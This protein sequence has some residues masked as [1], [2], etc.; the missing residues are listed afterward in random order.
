[1]VE[2][3]LANN[4]TATT[5]QRQTIQVSATSSV[6]GVASA[7]ADLLRD[8]EVAKVEALGAVAINRTIKAL[9][10]A[11]DVLRSDDMGIVCTPEFVELEDQH[12]TSVRF[13]VRPC[14]RAVYPIPP[15]S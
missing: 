7:I 14:G 10:M 15:V 5:F 2:T 9:A 1:M 11:R 3:A 8:Q 12:Q 4:I 6:R 13:T